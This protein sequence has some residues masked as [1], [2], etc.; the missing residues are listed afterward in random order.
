MNKTCYGCGINLQDV[1]QKQPGYIKDVNNDKLLLC[2]R[3]YRMQH[4]NEY[5]SHYLDSI[6]FE[7][8]LKKTIKPQSLV[9]LVV[10]L[11]DL[12]SSLSYKTKEIL[13][14]NPVLIV[15]SKRDLLLKSVNNNKL[16]N[17]IMAEAKKYNLNVVGCLISSATKK[18]GIDELLDSIFKHYNK[19]DVCIVGVTNVGKSSLINALI[20]SI[21]KSEFQVTISNYPGT[22]LDSIKI[23]LDEKTAIYDTPGIVIDE[24]MIH[25]LAIADYKYLQNKTEIKSRMFQLNELQTL[26]FGGLA[27]FSIVSGPKEGYACYAN[28]AIDIHRTKYENHIELYDKHKDDTLLVPKAIDVKEYNDF[29]IH[30]FKLKKDGSKKDIVILGLGWI[31]FNANGQVIEVAVPKN[32]DVV[33]RDALI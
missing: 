26:F 8:L 25:S 24:Q 27:S 23:E 7:K 12:N 11:F 1:D 13:R 10:D 5:Q 6:H 30:T 31:S 14:N 9:V 3:C 21:E 19:L 29:T 28:N 16:K 18:N 4:Y 32:V 22:T 20:N 17:Y 15:G 33:L 2:Q